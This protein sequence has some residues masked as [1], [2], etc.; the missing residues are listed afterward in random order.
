MASFKNSNISLPKN[1][2]NNSISTIKMVKIPKINEKTIPTFLFFN[3]I[4]PM[5]RLLQTNQLK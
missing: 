3:K 2:I 1:A 5:N 4:P